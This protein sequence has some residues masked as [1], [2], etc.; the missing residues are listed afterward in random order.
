MVAMPLQ[1]WPLVKTGGAHI[2]FEQQCTL[3]KRS[4]EKDKAKISGSHHLTTLKSLIGMEFF[5]FFL[6]KFSQLHA[7]LEPPRLL[8]FEEFSHL[9]DY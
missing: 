2:T 7:L 8:I 3:Y 4:N 1:I 9:H 5:L 6:R